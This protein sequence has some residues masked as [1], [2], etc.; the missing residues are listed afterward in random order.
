MRSDV[1]LIQFAKWPRRGRVKT[2]LAKA[3]GEGGALDAHIRLTMTVLER[4]RQSDYPI[5]LAW[6]AVM[7]SPPPEA[8]PILDAMSSAGVTVATQQGEDLGQRMTRALAD[9]L[10]QADVAMVI[11]SDCP[12]VDAVY[13]EQAR[14]ALAEA[15][16]VFGPSDDGG[17]VLIGAR[18][19]H[20]D[21]L[22]G[23]EWGSDTALAGSLEAVQRAGLRAATLDP[24]WDVDEPADWDRF[25][26][27]FGHS[28][29]GG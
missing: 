14:R 21:M 26:S 12:S 23:V 18:R 5:T 7:A 27:E 17:Y 1:R 16:V 19:V 20:P 29:T 28:S 9:A 22:A 6:D 8:S 25:L 10:Q 4:L 24:R 15:D 3:L 13:I 2:R 11:G